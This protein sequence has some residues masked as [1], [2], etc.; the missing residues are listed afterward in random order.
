[1]YVPKHFEENRPNEIIRIIKNFPLATLV[2]NSSNSLMANHLPLLLNKT[3]NNKFELVGHIAKANN[4]YN[5]VSNNDEVM[6]IFRSEDAYVSPNWYPS[7]TKNIEH[8]PTWNYQA[9]HLYGN[10][11]FINDKKIILNSLKELTRVFEKKKINKNDWNLS[12]VSNNFMSSML[13]EIVGIKI[14]ITKQ[15]AKSKLSQNRKKED[16]INVNKEIKN[17]G[18]NFLSNSMNKL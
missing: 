17:S 16:R 10:I 6:V 14:V 3:S 12:K 7:R 2:S 9:V 11:A 4:I 8:V 18:F 5:E 15:V 13:T 1:M